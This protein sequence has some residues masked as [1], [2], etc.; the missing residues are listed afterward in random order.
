MFV[1]PPHNHNIRIK[2]KNNHKKITL[3]NFEIE[4]NTI[5]FTYNFYYAMQIINKIKKYNK[6]F[7]FLFL[8]L[9]QANNQ[10]NIELLLLNQNVSN[11]THHIYTQ[12]QG[13]IQMFTVS[14]KNQFVKIWEYWFIEGKETEVVEMLADDI[15]GNGQNELVVLVNSFNGGSKVYVFSMIKNEPTGLPEIYE[16]SSQGKGSVPGFKV[17][18]FSLRISLNNSLASSIVFSTKSPSPG[19]KSA[20]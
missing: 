2:R 12:I 11:R 10:K 7:I 9:C 6:I 3:F 13:A 4:N 15:T 1:F 5:K 17:G 8:G 14:D 18:S 16:L 19:I 20:P